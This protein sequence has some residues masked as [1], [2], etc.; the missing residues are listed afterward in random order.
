MLFMEVS[1][2]LG[3]LRA[4]RESGGE[5]WDIS[6]CFVWQIEKLRGAKA[7]RRRRPA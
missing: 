4:H 7:G 1:E 3:V 6:D 2:I 5:T